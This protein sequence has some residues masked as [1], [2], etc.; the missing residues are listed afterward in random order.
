MG[1]HVFFSRIATNMYKVEMV[2]T[3]EAAVSSGVDKKNIFVLDRAY[4]LSGNYIGCVEL[5]L[6]STI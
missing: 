2:N 5:D 3:I 6:Y 4:Q 1:N